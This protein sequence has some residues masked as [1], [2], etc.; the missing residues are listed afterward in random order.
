MAD[1]GNDQ[2]TASP[3][4]CPVST[5]TAPLTPTSTTKEELQTREA[6]SSSPALTSSSPPTLEKLLDLA[7]LSPSSTSSPPS[8][9]LQGDQPQVLAAPLTD[10]EDPLL[11][12]DPQPVPFT[13]SFLTGSTMGCKAYLACAITTAVVLL[14]GGIALWLS[15]RPASSPPP[16][17]SP[18]T[19]PPPVFASLPDLSLSS[20]VAAPLPHNPSSSSSSLPSSPSS[21]SSPSLIEGQMAQTDSIAEKE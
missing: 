19:L 20:R 15:V 3:P 7:A 12:A 14:I 11:P 21:C 16:M 8:L 10:E 13:P 5:T 4:R 17:P 1:D 18:P 6:S 2:A 9:P